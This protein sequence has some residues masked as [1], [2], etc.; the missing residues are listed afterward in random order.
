MLHTDHYSLNQ[1]SFA[2]RQIWGRDRFALN[3]V[4]LLAGKNPLRLS[5]SRPI[6][7]RVELD[8]KVGS[9]M[10][11]TFEEFGDDKDIRGV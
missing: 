3:S 9:V 4:H 7:K 5:S 8:R 1:S 6:C 11:K 2:W 10:I